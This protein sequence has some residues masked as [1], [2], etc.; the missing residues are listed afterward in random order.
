MR[1]GE[2]PGGPDAALRLLHETVTLQQ[3]LFDVAAQL[4][5]EAVKKANEDWS[6]WLPLLNAEGA[7]LLTQPALLLEKHNPPAFASRSDQPRDAR[8]SIYRYSLHS[9]DR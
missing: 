1:T 7:Q 4:G 5:D 9:D 6:T 3:P 8:R 2:E